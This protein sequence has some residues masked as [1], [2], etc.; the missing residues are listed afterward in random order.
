VTGRHGW[1]VGQ[2]REVIPVARR[3]KVLAVTSV[4]VFM[5]LLDVTPSTR[6]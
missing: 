6:A 5:A 4:A 1:A 3:W 2:R